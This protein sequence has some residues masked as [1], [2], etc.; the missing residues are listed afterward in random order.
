MV[1]CRDTCSTPGAPPRPDDHP[2]GRRDWRIPDERWER[3][4]PVLPPR[5][6]QPLG[7]HRP[8]VDA[9]Q[10]MA[11]SVCGLRTGG[12]WHALLETG[13][14]AS[15]AAPRRWQEGAAAGV[16][17][18]WWT[19]GLADDAAWPGIAWA[20]LARAGAL[21][22][23]PRGGDNGGPAPHR[24]GHNRAQAPCPHR[25][26]RRASRPRR[27]GRHPPC[28]HEDMGDPRAQPRQAAGAHPGQTAGE[29]PGPRC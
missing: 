13:L 23:A 20:G 18:T 1:S 7:C 17:W 5:T 2:P 9:R 27:G 28:R 12:P 10:A 4:A 8:R 15:R 16:L 29:V 22:N 25:R 26:R 24:A 14:C 19:M 21:T 3:L 11:A 6:P